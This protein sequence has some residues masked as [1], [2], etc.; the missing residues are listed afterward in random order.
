[1]IN[2]LG[3]CVG[4][5]GHVQ[6]A[7]YKPQNTLYCIKALHKYTIYRLKQVEHAINEKDILASVSHPGIV[8]LFGSTNDKQNLYLILEYVPGGDL[9]HYIRKFG[10]LNLGTVKVYVAELVL[11]IEYLHSKNIV[12][13]DLKPEN[14]LVDKSG[15]L[16]LTDFGFS[17]FLYDRTWTLC[18]TPE[19]MAPEIILG[20]GHT[21]SVDWW[22]LGILTF[23]MLAGFPPFTHENTLGLFEKIK[24]PQ[25]LV[26]PNFFTVEAIDFISRLL[27]VDSSRRLGVMC[28]GVIDIK[29][30]PFFS[31]LNWSGIAERKHPPPYKPKIKNSEDISNFQNDL[32]TV[33]P[34]V[35]EPEGDIPANVLQFFDNF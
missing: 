27:E 22:S 7:R 18:G 16:K 12:Y 19:Y 9:F 21:K 34:Q 1:M 25:N 11:I 10:R 29:L 33:S 24:E 4:T 26:Y 14:I 28:R 5:Y 20:H 30:H 3:R 2:T 8:R 15:H 17:K 13:R 23:E 32:P 31:G 35:F 6:L